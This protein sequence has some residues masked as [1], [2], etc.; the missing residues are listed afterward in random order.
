MR[1]TDA[2]RPPGVWK[3]AGAIVGVAVL[4]VALGGGA[5]W[6]KDKDSTPKTITAVY[7]LAEGSQP[8]ASHAF[9]GGNQKFIGFLEN[10][11]ITLQCGKNYQYD[12]YLYDTD[13]Q[14]ARVTQIVADGWL[15]KGEDYNGVQGQ[16]D[17]FVGSPWYYKYGGDCEPPETHKVDICH[18]TASETNPY[19]ENSVSW[20]SVDNVYEIK[21]NGHGNHDGDIIPPFADF[22]GQNWDQTGQDIYNNGCVLPP[23]PPVVVTPEVPT[24]MDVC[25]IA[26]DTYNVPANTA[27]V[28]YTVEDTRVDGVGE[29]IIEAVVKEGYIFPEG[30][31]SEWYFEFTDEPCPVDPVVVTPKVPTATD[32]CGIVDDKLNVPAD[33]ASVVYT[34]DDQRVNGVGNVIVTAVAQDGYVFPENTVAKWTFPF[35]NEACALP[36][37]DKVQTEQGGELLSNG[38]SDS[39]SGLLSGLLALIGALSIT[40]GVNRVWTSRR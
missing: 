23:P 1:T 4:S 17:L 21:W 22:P 35:T 39:N 27:S 2:N 40:Y 26:N 15:T 18:A 10:G 12:P 31:T 38:A 24:M 11:G 28:V 36:V 29:V 6:A 30:T 14:I 34:V 19:T 20:S 5:A 8:N 7:E 33:T 37:P 25:G 9:D 32:A 3:R 16:P 13:A